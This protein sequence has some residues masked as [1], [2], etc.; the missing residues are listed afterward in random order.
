MSQRF[1]KG[2]SDGQEKRTHEA[3]FEVRAEDDAKPKIVGYAAVFNKRSVNFS[4]SEE[5]P[6]FEVIEPGAFRAAIND[7]VRAVIDHEGGLQTLGRTKAGTLAISEDEI[8]LRFELTP[9]DT[10]AGRDIVEL[11]KRGDIDQASFKFKVGP[12]GDRW[13]DQDD[14]KTTIRRIVAGGVAR[15]YD[16]SPVTFPAYESTTVTSRSIENFLTEKRSRAS[17]ARNRAR[18]LRLSINEKLYG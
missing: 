18:E 4:Y 9:P 16:V 5:Y 6:L 1:S 15:L 10:Q 14:G 17:A 8:G 11:I 12:D 3:K 13:E 2:P 7:D